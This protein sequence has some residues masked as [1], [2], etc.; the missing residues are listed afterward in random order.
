MALRSSWQ[1]ISSAVRKSSCIMH[2]FC[3]ADGIDMIH[4]FSA[5]AKTVKGKIQFLLR[6]AKLCLPAASVKAV[7]D[8][9]PPL[10]KRFVLPSAKN[11]ECL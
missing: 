11:I 9:V 5:N 2:P 3:F 7:H 1:V 4:P 6:P 8:S 10:V